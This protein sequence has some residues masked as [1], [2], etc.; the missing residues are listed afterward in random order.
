MAR[1]VFAAVDLGASSG[2]VVAGLVDGDRVE[3]DLVHRFD[4]EMHESDGHLRW[5]ITGLYEQVLDGLRRLADRFPDVE[6]VGID[7]WGVDYALLDGEGRLLAEP[8]AYRDAYDP[9]LVDAVHERVGIDVLYATT[10]IQLLP[11]NSIYRLAAEPRGPH[12]S[13]VAHAVL[14][15]DL[16]AFWLTGALATEYTNATTTGLVDAQ[17][18]DWSSDLLAT[19]GIPAT[20]LPPIEPPG[21]VRG[22]IRPA[23]RERLGVDATVV[24]TSVGSHDTASAVVAVP[25]TTRDFAYVSSGTW[26]LVGVEVGEPHLGMAAQRANFTNEGGVDGRIR[27]LRNVT[28]LWLLEESRRTWREQGTEHDLERLLADAEAL[29]AGGPVFDVDDPSLTTPGD[30]PARI[31]R[32]V[33]DGD[34]RA[35]C[36]PAETVRCIVDSLALA[37]VA[38]AHD[39]ARLGD[40]ELGVIHVVGG[41]SQ[42]ALLC[43]LTAD[44]AQTP[45]VAGPVEATALGNVLVQAR[46]H[47]A[48]HG[49]IDELRDRVVAAHQ[50]VRRFEPRR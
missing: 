16:L 23:L 38:T 33:G 45:V 1:R 35:L 41:G 9:R 29:P 20:L 17:T 6:S 40:V 7:T 13:R 25:A 8:V 48:L 49:T 21:T 26:S 14:L 22:P 12:W 15:P 24:V 44:L 34:G 27:L 31:A 50:P 47:G 28:G 18:R 43:R 36:T 5:N 46:A 4:N 37:Y 39:A 10:G 11:I 32:V 42:N 2:R 30:M 19:L 3:L